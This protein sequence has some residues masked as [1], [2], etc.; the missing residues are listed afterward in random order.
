MTQNTDKAEEQVRHILKS[1]SPQDF[2]KVGL[3]QIAYIRPQETPADDAVSYA[4][5]AADG[6][7]IVR[8]E[9]M[10]LA[11]AALRHNDLHAV[12]LH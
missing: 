5:H 8:L 4:I 1:L 2:L 10:D 9:S 12:T 3:H 7:E 6:S 11:I